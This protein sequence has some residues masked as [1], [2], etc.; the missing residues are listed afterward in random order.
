MRDEGGECARS[1]GYDGL[2]IARGGCDGEALARR[3]PASL[4][5]YP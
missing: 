3:G 1:R 4:I 2:A 5:L